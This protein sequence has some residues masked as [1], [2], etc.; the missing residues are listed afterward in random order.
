MVASEMGGGDSAEG[1]WHWVKGG[2][3]G[4]HFPLRPG[5]KKGRIFRVKKELKQIDV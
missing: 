5:E 1:K 2:G 3:S 4:K